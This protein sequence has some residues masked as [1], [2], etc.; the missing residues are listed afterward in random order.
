VPFSSPDRT[1]T[2]DQVL[3]VSDRVQL[4]AANG[5]Y[6]FSVPLETLGLHPRAGESIKA[7]IGVLRGN[8]TQTTQRVYW[9][10]K[11]TG[12]TSDVPSEAQLTPAL[13]GEW[14]FQPM[15]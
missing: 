9:S 4:D 5:N 13:W 8:G 3:D 12:I 1:I 15:H 10:D 2:I 6:A 11:A 7:D 14:V